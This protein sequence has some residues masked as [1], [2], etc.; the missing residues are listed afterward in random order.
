MDPALLERLDKMTNMMELL[1]SNQAK[2]ETSLAEAEAKS[3][4]EKRETPFQVKTNRDAQG[5]LL[6]GEG[7]FLRRN[8]F[9][10]VDKEAKAK[11]EDQMLRDQAAMLAAAKESGAGSSNGPKIK[12][13]KKWNGNVD[14]LEEWTW[15]MEIFYQGNFID[16]SGDTPTNELF[17][18]VANIEGPALSYYKLYVQR[19]TLGEEKPITKWK[20]FKT[21][22]QNYFQCT[23]KAQVARDRFK[24]LAQRGP[25][26]AYNEYVTSLMIE[27]P[28]KD[29]GDLVNDYVTGLKPEIRYPVMIE[30][31]AKIDWA[32]STALQVERALKEAK[33][34]GTNNR[35]QGSSRGGRG[36][37][38]GGARLSAAG[39][40]EGK[41][42]HNC[43]QTGHMK[44]QCPDLSEAERAEITR[45]FEENKAKKGKGRFA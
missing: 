3:E 44:W 41:S 28:N 6:F 42:C 29:M 19:A 17:H 11:V 5:S 16:I 24:R 31:P 35:G 18:A 4:S 12:P 38:R 7:T 13:P 43:G 22:M 33:P 14:Q 10:E 27:L 26:A 39:V 25:V 23:D 2:I 45:K 36:G 9:S 8:R 34:F 1:Q 21:L 32:M 37:N 20:E 30:K 15:G 40:S